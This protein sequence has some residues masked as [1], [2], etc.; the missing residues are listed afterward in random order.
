[1]LKIKSLTSRSL[2]TKIILPMVLV[3]LFFGGITAFLVSKL[4][5]SQLLQKE[6]NQLT[7]LTLEQAH[8][9]S[10][11]LSRTHVIIDQMSKLPQLTDYLSESKNK[12]QDEKILNLFTDFKINDT[13][14]AIYL[15][16]K[17][18]T[19][20]VSTDPKFIGQNYDFR[21]YF[22]QSISGKPGFDVAV[23]T[24]TGELG[25]F[26]SSPVLVDGKVAG[27]L[28]GKMDPAVLLDVIKQ[29]QVEAVYG[30]K[31]YRYITDKYGV[32]IFSD[33][34]D[35]LYN[36][37]GTL[38]KNLIDLKI[39]E[40]RYGNVSI[41]SLEYQAEMEAVL[42]KKIQLQ[43][44]FKD[45]DDEMEEVTTLA[46]VG[47]YPLYVVTEIGLEQI[48]NP[49]QRVAWIIGLIVIYAALIS[50][51]IITLSVRFWL[52]PL[53]KMR[54][55]VA[56]ISLGDLSERIDN[57]P[58]DELG[59][60]GRAFNQMADSLVVA[61]ENIEEQIRVRTAELTKLNG[62]M[63]GR[64]LK[65]TELKKQLNEAKNEKN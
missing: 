63:I 55:L 31:F 11:I 43:R 29:N 37:L 34:K 5:Y 7:G 17:E 64:E 8:E 59:E 38:P 52:R 24:M 42:Q 62:F 35:R 16:N 39:K 50:A 10:I 56:Q 46:K 1:M 33:R 26:L 4:M 18:G 20:I 19:A 47:D 6:Q 41:N 3:I 14:L 48:S 45:E 53:K 28:V 60:F 15:L 49:V 32:I 40:K 57:L 22:I 30:H 51:I 12:V 65:M 61:K 21:D 9:T 36:S 58:N 27:I 23:G 25:Y 44:A 13:F 54:Q 2:V